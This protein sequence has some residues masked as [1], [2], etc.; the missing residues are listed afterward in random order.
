VQVRPEGHD[1]PR[2]TVALETPRAAILNHDFYTKKLY[3]DRGRCFR[4]FPNDRSRGCRWVEKNPSDWTPEDIQT[5]LTR[6]AW[7]REVRLE[8]DQAEAEPKRT[9]NAGAGSS[10]QFSLTVRWESGLPVRLAHRTRT[11]AG[12]DPDRYVISIGRPPLS[13]LGAYAGRRPGEELSKEEVAAKLAASAW[14]GRAGKGLIRA[15][16]AHGFTSEFSPAVHLSFPR[17]QNPIELA[18]GEVAVT[19]RIGTLKFNARFPLKP[20]VYRERLEL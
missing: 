11:G 19:G 6:S 1:L 17:S 5:I 4:R 20:M 14:I 8:F 2:Q 16:N 15:E 9:T 10:S 18:D 12:D 13:F 7:V 3:D